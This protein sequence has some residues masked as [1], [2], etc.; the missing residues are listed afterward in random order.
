VGKITNYPALAG[1]SLSDADIFLGV[2]VS[3]TT[4]A[5][6]GSEVKM[7]A[8][9]LARGLDARPTRVNVQSTDYV[10]ALVDA[11]AIL[12]M[13]KATAQ[14]LTVPANASVPFPV[15]TIINVVQYGAGALTIVPAGAVTVRKRAA[16][17]MV[18]AGQYGG[19]TLYKRATDE[20]V[21]QGDLTAA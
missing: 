17:T 13:T 3:D 2:D 19:A 9:E 20:W 16:F 6:T 10:L 18:I 1:A 12:E 15:G 8:I 11:G 4:M 7:T 5:A 14:T 21:L